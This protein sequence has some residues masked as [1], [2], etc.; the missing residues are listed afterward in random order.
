MRA[1]SDAVDPANDG[2]LAQRGSSPAGDRLF[3]DLDALYLQPELERRVAGGL[4][5]ADTEIYRFQ[6]VLHHKGVEV[7][8]NEQVTG[9]A[10]IK[11]TRAVKAGEAVYLRDFGDIA[12]Y[13][14]PDHE[15]DLGHITAFLLHDGSWTVAWGARGGHPRRH[16]FF[17]LSEEFLHAAER[18]LAAGHLGAF[19]DNAFSAA[20]LMAKAEL[21]ACGPTVDLVL[22]VRDHGTLA[23]TYKRWADL[24]NT[25]RRFPKLLARLKKFRPSARYLDST[26]SLTE[27]DA[28]AVLHQLGEMAAFVGRRV[29]DRD[30]LPDEFSVYATRDLRAQEI[31]TTGD[32]GLVPRRTPGGRPRGDTGTD[33]EGATA[34]ERPPAARST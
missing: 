30:A 19:A 25:D 8:V 24:G 29:K 12:G 1:S 9:G 14:L 31:M 10:T 4:W 16:D 22:G 17:N 27:G 21:L 2:D 32:F 5:Q 33:A 3:F 6:A 11:V 20:E 23:S 15:R 13:E 7:R 28:A 34:A 18:A 26:L